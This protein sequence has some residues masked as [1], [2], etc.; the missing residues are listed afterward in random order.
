MKLEADLSHWRRRAR[1]AEKE[2]FELRAAMKADDPD[3][4]GELLDCLKCLGSTAEEPAAPA[5][6]WLPPHVCGH[7]SGVSVARPN[8]TRSRGERVPKVARGALLGEPSIQV[9]L[10][11]LVGAARDLSLAVHS[12]P[13]AHAG[14]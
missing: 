8:P 4:A 5:P 10:R 11:V 1:E 3:L 12:R 6:R 14:Q 13:A 2:C 7:R 9:G